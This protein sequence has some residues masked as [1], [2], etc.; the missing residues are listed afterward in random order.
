MPA[1]DRLRLA[2]RRPRRT[3]LAALEDRRAG[4]VGESIPRLSGLVSLSFREDPH[5]ID[6]ALA[7]PGIGIFSDVVIEHELPPGQLVRLS[8]ISLPGYVLRGVCRQGHTWD[9]YMLIGLD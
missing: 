8:G 2:L 9:Q 1:I 3:N 5:A 7:G 4:E 6:A